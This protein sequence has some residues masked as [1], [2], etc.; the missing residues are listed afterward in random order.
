MDNAF[1]KYVADKFYDELYEVACNFVDENRDIFRFDTSQLCSIGE[2]EV[3]DGEIKTIWIGQDEENKINYDV[4]FIATIYVKDGHRYS[5]NSVDFEKWLLCKCS[6]TF[7]DDLQTINIHKVDEYSSKSNFVNPLTQNLVPIINNYQYE[8]LAE[9]ILKKYYPEAL[10]ERV[11]ISPFL[12][13]EKLGLDILEKKIEKDDSILGRIY[14]EDTVA[15]LYDENLSDYVSINIKKDTILID[16]HLSPYNNIGR[17]YNTIFHECVHKV[18]HENIFKF[19]KITRSS[20]EAICNFKEQGKL[21]YTETHARK[22]APK[23]HMPKSRI[24]KRT[25]QLIN[26]LMQVYDAKYENEVMEVVIC[27]LSNEF[28]ASKQS[29]KIRLVELGFHSAIGTFTYVDGKYVKPHSFKKGALKNN[30]TYT[31]S[32]IDLAVERNCNLKLKEL[33]SEGDYIFVD[34]HLILNSSK[35]VER[36][37]FGLTLTPYALSHMDECCIKFELKIEKSKYAAD[38]ENNELCYLNRS[39]DS[40]YTF[41]AVATD[42][43]ISEDGVFEARIKDKE[44]AMNIRKQMT[45]DPTTFMPLLLKWRDKDQNILAYDI[46]M[47]PNSISRICTGKIQNPNL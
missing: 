39:R 14:F 45:D 41:R 33:T 12:L 28:N 21:S 2:F 46:D 5:D 32:F 23:L 4:L 25:H 17:Y 37:N 15:S 22:L 20:V 40:V 13:A 10:N 18:L 27:H 42:S 43:R 6:S 35:Y 7:E 11:E 29:V 3:I 1:T 26:E 8:D 44:E 24:I 16:T 38:C 9:Q 31:L 19:Q 47:T 34:N 36:T 30:E